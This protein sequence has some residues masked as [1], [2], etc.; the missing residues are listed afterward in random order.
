MRTRRATLTGVAAGTLLVL[1]G[2]GNGGTGVLATPPP[3]GPQPVPA[4]TA[5]AAVIRESDELAFGPATTTVAVGNVVEWRNAGT[6][7]H[8][9]T[10]DGYVQSSSMQGGE[11]FRLRFPKPGSFAYVCTYHA[12]MGGTITVH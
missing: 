2:C 12:G 4:G 5:A 6:T 9:V 1:T 11:S 7:P 3:D 8:N 10:F